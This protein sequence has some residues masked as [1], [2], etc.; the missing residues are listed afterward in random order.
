M[1]N[2]GMG[3]KEISALLEYLS[4]PVKLDIMRLA[5]TGVNESVLLKTVDGSKFNISGSLD[6]LRRR[7]L[8]ARGNEVVLTRT[9]KIVYDMII[10]PAI[11]VN[12]DLGLF[13][14]LYDVKDTTTVPS[15][16]HV[17]RT[18]SVKARPVPGYLESKFS[19]EL[20]VKEYGLNEEQSI[21]AEYVVN[22][23]RGKYVD[24]TVAMQKLGL[25]PKKD[26][27]RYLDIMETLIYSG[28][29]KRYVQGD[30]SKFSVNPAIL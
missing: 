16:P 30:E 8:V 22:L 9:G 11:K 28:I 29:A 20:L 26:G 3:T 14:G 5:N 17:E 24:Q 6:S 13:S 7:G 10:S 21:L 15:K 1:S 18:D 2:G 19:I 25:D 27:G 4:S 23:G 12:R